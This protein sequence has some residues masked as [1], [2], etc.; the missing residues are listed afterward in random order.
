MGITISVNDNLDTHNGKKRSF[1]SDF[2]DVA[3]TL[4]KK[5]DS[6]TD[7]R[8]KQGFARVAAGSIALDLRVAGD[9]RVRHCLDAENMDRDTFDGTDQ[10][11]DNELNESLRKCM[12]MVLAYKSQMKL[13]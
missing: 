9:P 11:Y 7:E 5:L 6:M 8:I 3:P 1:P 2:S 13:L 12:N 10:E 4:Q